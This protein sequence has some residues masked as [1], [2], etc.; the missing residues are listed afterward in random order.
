MSAIASLD[1]HVRGIIE[2]AAADGIPFRARTAHMHATWA[3]TFA[4][5]PELYIQPQ[6]QQE[7]EKAVKLARRCRRRITTVGHAHSPSDLTCTSNWLVNLD[8]F[9]K[10]LSV[11]GKHR[12]SFF[13]FFEPWW[14]GASSHGRPITC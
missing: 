9:K 2:D 14:G 5:L 3:R 12:N 10:V 7:V 6:S 13:T 8:G 11:D 4:S 1:P